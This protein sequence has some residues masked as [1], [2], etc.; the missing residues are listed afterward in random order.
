MATAHINIG[1]N[2]G[3][4]LALIGQA[5]AAV[6]L[7]FNTPA[8]CSEPIE[9]EPWGFDSPNGFINIGVNIEVGE[10]TPE[11]VLQRL[12]QA[13]AQ[14]DSSPHRN[15]DGGYIDRLIDIDLIAID[16]VVIDTE[17]LTLPHPRMHLREFVLRPMSELLPS[18]RHPLLNATPAELLE[19]L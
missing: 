15:A 16:N 11:E 5:V 17:E 13:Q 6:E 3:D 7:I 8:T 14:I 1:S 4:R 19:R 9:S 2:I 12:L 10:M 18:W